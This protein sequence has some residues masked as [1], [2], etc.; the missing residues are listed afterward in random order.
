MILQF[1]QSDVKKTATVEDTKQQENVVGAEEHVIPEDIPVEEEYNGVYLLRCKEFGESPDKLRDNLENALTTLSLM[2]REYPT[3]PANP[4]DT[5]QHMQEAR[6][7]ECGLLLPRKHCAFSGCGWNGPDA[8][9]F[10]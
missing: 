9:F 8:M 7:D 2:F 1:A 10:S 6:S 5:T 3:L 4:E